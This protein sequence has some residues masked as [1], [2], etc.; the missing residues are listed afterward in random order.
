MYS[1]GIDVAKRSHEAC[2]LDSSGRTVGQPLKFSSSRGGADKLV[3]I[4]KELGDSATIALE[5]SGHYWQG[6]HHYLVSEGFPVVVANP[7]QTDAYRRTGMRKVKNDRRDAFVIADFLRI[8]RVQA[9]YIPG[10]VIVQLRELTRYRMDLEDQI[11][12]AKRRILTVLDRVFPEYPG[13][14]PM[15]LLPAPVLCSK[16]LSAL[17]TS[18]PSTLRSSLVSSAGPAVVAWAGKGPRSSRRRLPIPWGW[19]S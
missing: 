7:L 2:V 19:P 17:P 11:G 8:G 14:S 4:L 5:A 13:F 18:L 10:E 1:V 15:S 12:D 16:K 9:N 3:S 6:L